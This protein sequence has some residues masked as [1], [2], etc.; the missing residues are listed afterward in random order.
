MYIARLTETE[1]VSHSVSDGVCVCVC[2]PVPGV[3]VCVCTKLTNPAACTRSVSLENVLQTWNKCSAHS[4]RRSTHLV[5]FFLAMVS[6]KNSNFS[7]LHLKFSFLFSFVCFVVVLHVTMMLKPQASAYKGDERLGP[8][9]NTRLYL[10]LSHPRSYIYLPQFSVC[11]CEEY[12]LCLV[13]TFLYLILQ[14]AV[15]RQSVGERP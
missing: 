4:P 7:L 5:N 10:P 13:Y 11:V 3:C 12:L 14:R 8:E 1:C 15:S 9:A 6:E 2:V